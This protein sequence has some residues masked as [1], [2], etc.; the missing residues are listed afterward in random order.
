M[1]A[2]EI[3]ELPK[4]IALQFLDLFRLYELTIGCY[5]HYLEQ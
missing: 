4:P 2:T 5:I 3:N 1:Q